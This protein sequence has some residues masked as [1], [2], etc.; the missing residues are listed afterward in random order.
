MPVLSETVRGD[1]DRLKVFYRVRLPTDLTLLFCAGFLAATGQ[2]VDA[3]YDR[4]YAE[5]SW[6]HRSRRHAGL[7]T[8]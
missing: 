8:P 2:L 4:R 6:M 5:A 1:R 7:G 3:L